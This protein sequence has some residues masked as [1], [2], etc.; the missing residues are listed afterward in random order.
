[1]KKTLLFLVLLA[2]VVTSQ[3][4][5]Q[6]CGQVGLI[7]EFTGWADDHFMDRDP[8]DPNMF[9]TIL[10]LTEEDSGDP[11]DG[12]VELKFRENADWAV[13]WGDTTFPAGVAMQDGGNIPVPVGSYYVTFNCSTGEYL[14]AT[15]CDAIGLIGEFNGWADDYWMMRDKMDPNQWMV[16]FTVTDEQDTNEDGFIEAK[17]REGA[18][19]AVNWGGVEFPADTGY[20]DGPNIMVPLDTNGTTTDYSVSFNCETGIYEFMAVGGTISMIGEFNGWAADYAMMRMDGSPNMWYTIFSVTDAQDDNGDG[21]IEAKFRENADWGV[22][23]GGD[24]FPMGTGYQDGPNLMVPLDESGITTDY[25]VTF[26]Y[27]TG[28]YNFVATCGDMSMIGAFINWNGDIPMNRDMMNPNE[29]TLTRSFFADAEVKFRENAD[30]TNNWGAATFPTGVGEPNGP[31]IPL[32]MGVYDIS[33]NCETFEYSFIENTDA[34]GEIGMVGDFNEWGDDGTG[35][36]SDVYLVRDPMYPS[37]FSLTYNFAGTT[38]LLFRVDA[39]VTFQNVWGGTYPGGGGV[40]GDPLATITVPG[41]K[42]HITFNCVAGD[43]YF[44]RLGNAITAPEVFAINVDGELS[45]TDWNLSQSVSQIIEGEATE[46]LNEVLFGAAWNSDYFFFGV[47]VKDSLVEDGDIVHV[48]IDGDKSGGDYTAAD[49]HLSI[50]GTGTLTVVQGPVSSMGEWATTTGG[51]TVEFGIPWADLGITPESGGQVGV[52]VI[53]GDDDGA[54]EPAYFMSWNGNMDNLTTTD[55][56]GD[57]NLGVIACGCISLYNETIGDMVLRNP[58]DLP[59][60]YVATYEIFENQSTVFRKDFDG[61]VFWGDNSFPTGT[62]GLGGADIPTTPGRY[63]ITFDCL[64][65]E[66]SFVADPTPAEGIA[67][68]DRTEDP[69]NIDGDLSEYSLNYTSDILAAGA[70]PINNTVTWGALWDSYNLY[71]GVEVEDAVVEGSGNPWDNDAIEYYFDGN[72]DQDETYDGDF[73]T[74]LIQDFLAASAS[75]DTLWIKADGVQFTADQ[76]DAI[77]TPTGS[78]YN[79]ELRLA[80][81]IFDFHPGKGRT[82]GF[83]LGNNDSDQGLGRDYQ[84]VWY[85]DG[86]NWSNTAVLGDLQLAGGPYFDVKEVFYNDQMVLFPNPTSG[87]INIR[88]I[89]EVFQGEMTF[90]V[91]D[92]SGRVIMIEKDNFSGANDM[93]TLRTDHLDAG[94]Y[95]VNIIAADG[96]KALK[97]LIVR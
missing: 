60:T 74:Q 76:Y 72:H 46:D 93:I 54:K 45:E 53:V 25:M 91:S 96:K 26:D 79:L 7:G 97:K 50:D 66:Y 23:W 14:F 22:N 90:Y 75:D 89:G 38:N 40:F 57:C 44:E 24:D 83:S 36:P 11:P 84:S 92:I 19:W 18:D 31:N 37:L 4:F 29:W 43:F 8:M 5:S 13:N 55:G 20:Q 17:F 32:V 47:S 12:I 34:C 48:F 42:Y 71:L 68:A 78:G 6:T 77:W 2:F 85:G 27:E 81:S 10:V 82:M 21:F 69:V 9:S 61:T 87:N 65:G 28:D 51:Y 64:T 35:T 39:D 62:A 16:I 49:A 88:A 94:I 67:Y 52:D 80:W 73:D 30:W 3:G 33:F 1:M 70:G 56:F 86:N 59:T 41:G 63:R 58:T 95:F 15:T